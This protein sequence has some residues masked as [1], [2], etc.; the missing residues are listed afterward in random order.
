[1]PNVISL[2]GNFISSLTNLFCS[3]YYNEDNIENDENR[4]LINNQKFNYKDIE[5]NID[6][7]H[8]IDNNNPLNEE[9]IIIKKN[10]EDNIIKNKKD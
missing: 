8:E 4:D 6:N 7:Q 2:I 5:S 1:M 3:C 10:N 9:K